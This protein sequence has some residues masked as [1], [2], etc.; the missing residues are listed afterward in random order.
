MKAVLVVT[1]TDIREGYEDSA[2]E[3]ALDVEEYWG[4]LAAAHRCSEPRW[5]WAADGTSHWFVEGEAEDL[6]L[7]SSTPRARWLAL[8]G[9]FVV[10]GYNEDIYASG[11]RRWGR[12]MSTMLRE[13]HL[14]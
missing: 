5:W 4:R 7:L 9:A 1:W 12:S 10:Q 2:V 14:V 13:S 8:K 6:L 11:A 3:Y